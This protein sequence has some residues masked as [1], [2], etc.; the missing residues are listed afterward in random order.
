MRVLVDIVHPAHAHFYRRMIEALEAEGA[1]VT[2]V[3]REK[4]VTEALLDGWGIPHVTIGA[5]G[6]KSTL[7]QAGALLQRDWALWR[8]ARRFHPDVILTRN[9]SGVQVARLVGAVGIFDTDDGRKAG[10]H[11]RA[12][13]PFAHI[14]TTPDVLDEDYGKKHRKFHGYKALA[15]LHPSRYT[16]DPGVR[17][18]LGVGPDQRYFIVRFVAM[19]A[20]HDKHEAGLSNSAKR[21]IVDELLKRGRVFISSEGSVPPDLADLRFSLPPDRI[22]DAL[23]FADLYVGD[24]QT[25]AAEAALLGTP[26]LRASSWTGRLD[27]LDELENDWGLVRSFKPEEVDE[28]VDTMTSLVDDPDTGRI[29]TERRDRMLADKDD[30]TGWYLDLIHEVARPKA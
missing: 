26:A 24:S 2:V 15:Y 1:P 13:A 5:S 14:I 27:Y 20:S 21:R 28:L 6:A 4:D 12:A 23:A 22:H 25:M 11:F 7:G 8:I 18:L 17:E 30:V 10:I 29:W 9:P 16:P 3:S 19:D